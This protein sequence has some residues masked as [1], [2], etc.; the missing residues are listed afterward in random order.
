W[1][2]LWI[3]VP[4]LFY[5]NAFGQDTSLGRYDNGTFYLGGALNT[6]ALF[7]ANGSVVAARSLLQVVPAAHSDVAAAEGEAASYAATRFELNET[8]YEQ[9]APIRI[10]TYFAMEYFTGFVVFAA[11]L[12]HDKYLDVPDTWYYI[13]LVLNVGLGVVVCHFGGFD[14]PWWGVFL[15]LLLAAVSMIPIGTIQAVTGQQIGLNVMSEFLIGLILPGRMV[16]VMT[17]KTLSYM[18]MAQGLVLVADLKLGHYMKIPPRAMFAVQLVSTVIAMLVDVFTAF[19][20]YDNIG[21]Q[22]GGASGW[23]AV[24]Y[25]VFFNAGAIWGAVGPARFFG[26]GSPYQPLLWGFLIGFVLPALLYLAHRFHGG[27]WW[28]YINIPVI[29][30]FPSQVGST[31]S[32][33]IT[34][35]LIGIGINYFVRKYNHDWWHKYALIMSAGFDTGVAIAVAVIFFAITMPHNFMPWYVLH[36]FDQEACAPADYLRACELDGGVPNPR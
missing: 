4:V 21:S 3:I 7:A 5:A 28:E 22:F 23:S 34:P 26:A 2:F 30:V 19:Y 36:R 32:D 11:T 18:A 9:V 10:T 14:L 20:I 27:W 8:L 13:L 17:F 25:R 31:R 15:A 6:P 24:N 35:L 16:A 12:S 1:L 29:A 33:L